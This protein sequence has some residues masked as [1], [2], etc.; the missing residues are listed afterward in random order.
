MKWYLTFGTSS[1]GSLSPINFWTNIS[2]W[3]W[4]QN[5]FII[6]VLPSQCFF[7]VCFPYSSFVHSVWLA[8]P[9]STVGTATARWWQR[10][11]GW[12]HLVVAVN[13]TSRSAIVAIASLQKYKV[14]LHSGFLDALMISSMVIKLIT[15]AKFQTTYL[16]RYIQQEFFIRFVEIYR[17]THLPTKNFTTMLY[18]QICTTSQV[19]TSMI[20]HIIRSSCDA[21]VKQTF[22]IQLTGYRV[23]PR[24]HLTT[25]RENLEKYIAWR[26]GLIKSIHSLQWCS[27]YSSQVGIT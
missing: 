18:W 7:T 24:S 17:S 23:V 1:V 21:S 5:E 20:Y 26:A 15:F 10:R 13:Q 14:H 22:A 6:P 9:L 16:H 19:V 3:I 12:H 2:V 4:I 8:P 25:P 27:S 11:A